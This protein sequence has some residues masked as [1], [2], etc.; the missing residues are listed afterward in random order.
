M[1][2]LELLAAHAV[3]RRPVVV[4]LLQDLAVL[5]IVAIVVVVVVVVVAVAIVIVIVIVIVIAI[6]IVIV[7]VIVIIIIIIM[8]IITQI[9][10]A[11][12]PSLRSPQRRRSLLLLAQRFVNQ[13]PD[14]S[15]IRQ[16]NNRDVHEC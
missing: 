10:V 14:I 12:R 7:I 13:I 1:R 2:G 6:V 9:P 11:A 8:Q 16:P 3:R 4:V 5:T 15:H